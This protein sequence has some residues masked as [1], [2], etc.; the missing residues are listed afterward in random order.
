MVSM[1]AILVHQY[2]VRGDKK[3]GFSR[4]IIGEKT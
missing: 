1:D 2:T 4:F 3:A